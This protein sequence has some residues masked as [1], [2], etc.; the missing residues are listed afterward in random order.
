MNK[1]ISFY[2]DFLR[3]IAAFG[4][5]LVH[6]NLSQFSNNLYL[7]PDLGYKLVR[8]FFV[9][10]GYLIAFTVSKKNKESIRY[11]ID[12]F[13]RLYSVVFI[14]AIIPYDKTKLS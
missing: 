2:L 1:S 14:G 9:L 6:A 12:R 5:L 13:S 4:V 8:V 11:L 7:R 10:S 3:V